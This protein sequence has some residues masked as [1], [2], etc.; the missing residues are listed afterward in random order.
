MLVPSEGIAETATIYRGVTIEEGV[1]IFPGAVI[2]RPPKKS[3]N[4]HVPS[5]AGRDTI[6]RKGAVIGCNAV[7]YQGCDIGEDAM[8]GDG[9][10]IR[11]NSTIGEQ[12]IVG[13]NCTFQ[14]DVTMGKRSRVIDLSHITAGVMIGDD[15]FISTGVLTMNDNS[16]ARGGELRPPFIDSQAM[17]GGGAILLPG[18]RVGQNAIVAAGAVVTKSVKPGTRVQGVPAKPFPPHQETDEEIWSDHFFGG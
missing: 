16:M 6:I 15:V 2:G 5:R 11:E 17:V 3:G 12:S 8:V 9:A 14:N 1:T 10:T 4:F 18:V 13:N 7:I